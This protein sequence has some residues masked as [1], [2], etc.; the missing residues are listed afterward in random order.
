[1]ATPAPARRA[2]ATTLAG[3]RALLA[4]QEAVAAERPARP[5]RTHGGVLDV[6]GHG[7]HHRGGPVVPAVEAVRPGR[8]SA[9]RSSPAVPAIGRPSGL[10]P[11]A[12]AANRLWTTSSGS[13]SC[14]AIS[15]R[16]T[17]RS[18]STSSG[19]S[20]ELVSMSPSTSTASGRSSSSTR[21]WKQVYSFAVKALNSP[22]TASSSIEMSSADRS[23]VPLKSRCSRKCEQPCSAGVSSREPTP[24]QTP[25]LAE[26]TPAM[27]S[28]TTRS[29]LGSTVRRTREVTCPAPSRTVCSVRVTPT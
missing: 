7:H 5:C 9:P 15:S 4:V 1:M 26:R 18:A 19:S 24:T 21:A 20:S 3:D 17:S 10:S 27:C 12:C 29:P 13:S 28:V 25:M 16:I 22:P 14:M 23:A 2:R 8:G 6:A 11:Q